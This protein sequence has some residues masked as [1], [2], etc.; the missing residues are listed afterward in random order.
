MI[1]RLLPEQVSA[2]WSVIKTSIRNALPPHIMDTDEAMNNILQSCMIGAMQVWVLHE[3]SGNG[4]GPTVHAIGTTTMIS[5][6]ISGSRS[7][8]LYSLYAPG[9]ISSDLWMDAY[10]GISKYAKSIGCKSV[11]AYSNVD[12]ALALAKRL[13]G[14]TSY[15]LI[16]MGVT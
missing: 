8:L 1:T 13:G 12:A 7:L 16:T 9:G 10:K 11:L 3:Q 6:P 14:D 4:V 5:D 15:H 2:R